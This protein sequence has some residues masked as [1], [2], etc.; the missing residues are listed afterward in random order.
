MKT[1]GQGW[2]PCLRYPHHALDL[3]QHRLN[4]LTIVGILKG[5]FAGDLAGLDE[6]DKALIHE[7]H[8]PGRFIGLDDVH[9]GARVSAS[10]V[11]L[12]RWRG[13][14]HLRCENSCSTLCCWHKLLGDDGRKDLSKLNLH[15]FLLAGREHM[16]ADVA[17]TQRRLG[18]ERRKD[19]VS[20]L[21]SGSGELDGFK[22][23]HLTDY[24]DVRC[25]SQS[26]TKSVCKGEG[27][28]AHLTLSNDR[29]FVSVE[30]LHQQCAQ[31]GSC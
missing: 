13:E 25:L 11:V 29:L 7:S 4:V 16:D 28:G 17:R 31:H 6:C 15:L 19:E 22:V 10:D 30:K 20:R 5:R 21:G 24:D 2:G 26:A 14:H 27:V 18:V 1:G 3:L 8:H 9:E 23:S 12:D